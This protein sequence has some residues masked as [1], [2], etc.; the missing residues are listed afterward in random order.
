MDR[1]I[2]DCLYPYYAMHPNEQQLERKINIESRSGIL[3]LFI[4]NI[5]YISINIPMC[6][7]RLINRPNG[8]YTESDDGLENPL[9][10]FLWIGYKTKG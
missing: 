5:K 3:Y 2:S 10:Y 9:Q 6:R 4:L 1:R 8:K 7:W